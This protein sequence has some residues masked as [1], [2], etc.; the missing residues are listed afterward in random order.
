MYMC[1]RERG[2][3]ACRMA[4]GYEYSCASAVCTSRPAC[5]MTVAGPGREWVEALCVRC[6]SRPCSCE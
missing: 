1:V 5:H 6:A 4:S 2:A 3:S